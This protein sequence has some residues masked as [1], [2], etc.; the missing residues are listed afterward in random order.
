[1]RVRARVGLWTARTSALEMLSFVSQAESR[2]YPVSLILR[3]D[4]RPITFMGVFLFIE[5]PHMISKLPGSIFLLLVNFQKFAL[6]WNRCAPAFWY[7]LST[8]STP[9][10]TNS[11]KC[12]NNIV[13]NLIF[14]L[15][16]I[17]QIRIRGTKRLF[18]RDRR[19]IWRHQHSVIRPEAQTSFH[20]SSAL[21]FHIIFS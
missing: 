13:K 15:K 4:H 19:S 11:I 8:I 2:S 6:F 12:L 5:R 3:K 18:T 17:K 21:R 7:V 14:Q 16:G 10:K 1:M 20:I 9:G